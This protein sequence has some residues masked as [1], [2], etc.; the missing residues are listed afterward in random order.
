MKMNK[1][2]KY[3]IISIVAV[4]VVG[5]MIWKVKNPTPYKHPRDQKVLLY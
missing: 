4:A 5:G 3:I 2:I 1:L